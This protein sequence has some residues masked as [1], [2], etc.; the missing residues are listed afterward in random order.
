[1]K[2]WEQKLV[3]MG[4]TFAGLLFLLAAV[5]KPLIKGQPINAV[6]LI[7]GALCLI[8]GI[9]TWRKSGGGFGSPSA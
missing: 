8:L 6:F 2:V 9:A 7:L 4:F 3:P 5:V 1:M